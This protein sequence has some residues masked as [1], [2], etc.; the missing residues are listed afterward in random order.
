MEKKPLKQ[1]ANSF[2]IYNSIDDLAVGKKTT[3][4]KKGSKIINRGSDNNFPYRI[5][6]II[7]RSSTLSGVINSK[8]EFVSYGDLTADKKI[9]DKL[10]NDC[11]ALGYNYY[12]LFK[13][14][15]L[16][17]FSIGYAILEVVKSGKDYYFNH[18]DA[19]KVAIIDYDKKIEYFAYSSDF[20]D[21]KKEIVKVP[22]YPE[23]EKVGKAER[24]FIMISDYNINQEDYPL[25][26]WLGCLFDA[27][28]ESL[29]GQYNANQFENGVTLSSILMFDFGDTPIDYDNEEIDYQTS[30]RNKLERQ[31]KGTSKG[32]SGKSLIVPMNAGVEKPE[33]ITYP[34]EKEG[35]YK[36]LQIMTENNIIKANGW[37][38]SLAG[39]SIQGQL[40][41]TNQLKNEWQLAERLIRNVQEILIKPIFEVLDYKGQYSFINQS[42]LD[43]IDDIDKVR[44]ILIDEKLTKEAKKELLL[45]LGMDESKINKIL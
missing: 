5:S 17:Y 4:T 29:I 27:Q 2:T 36:D 26:K 43:L 42:P 3:S 28:I 15:S 10:I 11:S 30:M 41:N 21:A 1:R 23:F 19:S 22:A 44:T 14:L 45:I 13:R 9:V 24:A 33:Y 34:M 25:P 7:K 40:G 16:D 38:R 39:L 8:A 18:V 31:L 12:E 35:S 20:N 32:R 6:D 37:Y